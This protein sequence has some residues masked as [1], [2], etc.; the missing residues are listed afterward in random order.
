MRSDCVCLC[1]GSELSSPLP[2][3]DS[4]QVPKFRSSFSERLA[5]IR[6]LRERREEEERRMEEERQEEEE[7]RA[8]EER[9]QL[10]QVMAL[11]RQEYDEDTQLQ[12]GES[13]VSGG[14]TAP[15]LS[16]RRHRAGHCSQHA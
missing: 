5:A 12:Q 6:R 1:A 11:S 15:P 7:R 3:V 9:E 16:S 14:S 8:H 13:T 10:Q 4:P 2:R